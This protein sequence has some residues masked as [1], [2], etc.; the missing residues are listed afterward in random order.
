MIDI[1]MFFSN[2]KMPRWSIGSV[3]GTIE[4]N[5]VK[6]FYLKGLHVYSKTFYAWCSTFD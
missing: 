5:C 6:N 2:A 4:P 3:Y 1:F